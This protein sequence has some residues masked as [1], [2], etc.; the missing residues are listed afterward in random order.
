MQA[1][2][3][4][5]L[6]GLGDNRL[7]ILD[8]GSQDINGSYKQI[9]EKAQWHYTGADIAPGEN[10]DLI[11]KNMY[12]WGNIRSNS[13]DVVISGQTFEHIEYFWFTIMEI[14]RILKTGG[15]CCI[16][17][18]SSGD[19]HK[20]PVDCWRFY[21]DGFKSLAEYAGLQVITIYT[22]WSKE[23]YPDYDS[24][25]KDTV[26]ICRK[27]QLMFAKRL[28]LYLKNR[29]STLLAIHFDLK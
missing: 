5:Y 16:I 3:E 13:Y 6:L 14:S 11:L 24:M 15:L 27:R 18:P 28:K 4:K 26:L 9:F 1:F 29:L 25:W 10:V 7:E 21:P 2:A 17:A 23:L 20:Y 22:Q 8:I 12:N 19:E